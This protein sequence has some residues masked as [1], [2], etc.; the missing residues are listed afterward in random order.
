[1]SRLLR[2]ANALSVF[3][4]RKAVQLLRAARDELKRADCPVSLAKV[5]RAIKSTEGALR[6]A[7]RR[8]QA[9]AQAYD[10]ATSDDG[11]PKGD[12]DCLAK[13]GDCHDACE[14]PIN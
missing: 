14:S 2:Q 10:N 9:F 12:P 6:H 8:A 7:E 11:C 1:M 3:E 13:N 4:V 5:R